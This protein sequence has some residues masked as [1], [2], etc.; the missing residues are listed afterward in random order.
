MSA[1]ILE[2]RANYSAGRIREFREQVGE[3]VPEL[4]R[5]G[6]LCIYTTGSFGRGEAGRHSD[7]DLFFA[8]DGSR[9]AVPNLTKT[10]IDADLIRLCQR[11][12]YP[13]FS[14][15]GVYLK[16]HTVADLSTKIGEPQEDA[17]NVFTARMLLFLESTPLHNDGIYDRAITACVNAYCRDYEDHSTNFHPRFLA[18]DIMRFWKTLC[19]NYESARTGAAPEEKPKHWLKNFKLKF[20]RM[21]TCFSMLACLSDPQESDNPAKLTS[22]VQMTPMERIRHITGKHHLTDLFG[23]L[24][25]EYEWF[26]TET[27]RDKSSALTWIAENKDDVFRRAKTFG[28]QIYHLLLRVAEAT[29]GDLRY[30]VV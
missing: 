27:D 22:L 24:V 12:G 11:L 2:A 28:D 9:A 14:G 21:M 6:N 26:L 19:L 29:G 20:S 10:L 3:S 7:L 25:S 17:E 5:C 4:A 18:N 15:D 16:I 13:A 30:L 1:S 8:L 23:S